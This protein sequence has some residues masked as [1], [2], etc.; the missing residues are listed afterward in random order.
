MN[1]RHGLEGGMAW[2]VAQASAEASETPPY[3]QNPGL[4]RHSR[5]SFVG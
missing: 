1:T 2:G 4:H 5:H 3:P